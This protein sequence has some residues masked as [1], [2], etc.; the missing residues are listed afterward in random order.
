MLTK[1]LYPHVHWGRVR[2]SRGSKYAALC[3]TS[4]QN[5]SHHACI[6]ARE[7]T[8]GAGQTEPRLP[9]QVIAQKADKPL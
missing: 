9:R 4:S 8:D 7:G 1:S 2:V 3:S 5:G 6:L